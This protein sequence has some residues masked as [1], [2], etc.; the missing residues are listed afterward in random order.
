MTAATEQEA[1]GTP[2]YALTNGQ[3]PDSIPSITIDEALKAA[4]RLVRHFGKATTRGPGLRR[5]DMAAPTTIRPVW[6]CSGRAGSTDQLARGWRRLVHDIAHRVH[7]YRY[8]KRRPHDPLHERLEAE[9]TAYV[10]AKGWLGGELRP[11]SKPAPSIDDKRAQ[12]LASVRAR[13]KRWETKAK[14]AA[15]AIKKLKAT[16]RRLAA[17]VLG[18]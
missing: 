12:K 2:R 1:E 7:R 5:V 3:W 14:R 4:R 10:L 16:E 11:A 18:A 17:A 15:T 9:M 8:P 13:L 6:A